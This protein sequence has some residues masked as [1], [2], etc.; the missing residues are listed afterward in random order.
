MKKITFRIIALTLIFA[1]L[2]TI[3][4]RDISLAA[5]SPQL[6]KS[7]TKVTREELIGYDKKWSSGIAG[8]EIQRVRKSSLSAGGQESFSPEKAIKNFYLDPFSGAVNLSIPLFTPPGRKGAQPSLTL[9]YSSRNA[10]GPFGWGWR[11]DIGYIER[12]TKEGVPNYN[13]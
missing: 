4:L 8:K 2:F 1:H 7:S 6:Q 5:G 10:N 12:S 9:M 3:C 13:A 11:M